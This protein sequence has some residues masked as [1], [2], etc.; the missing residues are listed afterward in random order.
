VLEEEE[1]LRRKAYYI[2]IGQRHFYFMNLGNGE[3]IDASRKV[4]GMRSG[5]VTFF[6]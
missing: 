2:E 6:M 3:I 4:R 5:S 1:Y